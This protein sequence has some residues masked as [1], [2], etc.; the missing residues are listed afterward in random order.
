M[1]DGVG[2]NLEISVVDLSTGEVG[3]AI[4]PAVLV[5][6]ELG[7]TVGE[8]K[9]Y[10]GEVRGRIYCHLYR[11]PSLPPFFH[12]FTSYLLSIHHV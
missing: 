9:Q 2:V 12:L 3:P 8:L 5:R 1:F 11:S 10:I 6:V 7:W 4:G